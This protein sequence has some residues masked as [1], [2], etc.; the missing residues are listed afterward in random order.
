[1]RWATIVFVGALI[2]GPGVAGPNHTIYRNEEFGITLRVP[3]EALLCVQPENQH[4][5]GPYM[6]LGTRDTKGCNDLEHSRSIVVFASY[7]I[8]D[9]AKRLSEFL[10][11]L[12]SNEQGRG[13]DPAPPN[14]R[15]TGL[16]SAAGEATHAGWLD[17]IV[18]TKAGKPD[19]TFDPSVPSMNYSIQLHTKEKY[20]TEDLRVFRAVLGAIKIAPEE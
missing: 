19:P 2:S 20:F 15:L 13:C 14:L 8:S 5:H 18:G 3:P 12:C 10:R 9:E 16:P 7:N 17:V 6:L 11:W 1:M 4:D